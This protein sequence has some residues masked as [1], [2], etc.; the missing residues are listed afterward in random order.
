MVEVRVV[1]AEG[2][3]V[4]RADVGFWVVGHATTDERGIA[5]VPPFGSDTGSPSKDHAKRTL[6]VR[7]RGRAP[8]VHYGTVSPYPYELVRLTRRGGTIEGRCVDGEGREVPDVDLSLSWGCRRL[9]FRSDERGRF[10]FDEAAWRDGVLSARTD[11]LIAAQ[12]VVVPPQSGLVLTLRR[13]ARVKGVLGPA[14]ERRL[15]PPVVVRASDG[16]EISMYCPGA[17]ELDVAPGPVSVTQGERAIATRI[18]GEGEDVD[19]EDVEPPSTDDASVAPS[20]EPPAPSWVE[21]DFV[22]G[23]R[24]YF[25]VS[26]AFADLGLRPLGYVDFI[27]GPTRLELPSPRLESLVIADPFE[28]TIWRQPARAKTTVRL[29]APATVEVTVR[30]HDAA[31]RPALDGRL[32]LRWS[33]LG[34]P[35]PSARRVLRPWFSDRTVVPADEAPGGEF[36]IAAPPGDYDLLWSAEDD[37][38]GSGDVDAVLLRRDVRVPRGGGVVDLGDLSI[39]D[40][41]AVRVRVTANGRPSPFAIV[42]LTSGLVTTTARADEQGAALLSTPDPARL[43]I[44]AETTDGRRAVCPVDGVGGR[45][46]DVFVAI[47]K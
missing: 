31:G 8:V 44:E 23:E 14:W 32:Q 33:D 35:G 41:L 1:D 25:S 2:A 11:A 20:P 30:L 40:P 27:E 12:R 34:A 19:F 17:F 38:I 36:R 22:G 6:I 42:R 9:S 21:F 16:R 43:E 10:L 18:A 7:A 26:G 4:P 5:F 39:P 37:M 24:S 15:A 28:S 13:T 29:S 47:R 3:P 45:S 46:L